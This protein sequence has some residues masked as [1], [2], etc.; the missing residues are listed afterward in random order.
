VLE[1]VTIC[2]D[3]QTFGRSR[4]RCTLYALVVG[5]PAAGAVSSRLLVPKASLRAFASS[6]SLK[7]LTDD[8]DLQASDMSHK[9]MPVTISLMK[10]GP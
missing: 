6:P 5:A 2:S 7:L 1:E 10:C 3:G 4:W 8:A 9:L